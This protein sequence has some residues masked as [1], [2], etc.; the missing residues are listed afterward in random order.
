MKKFLV[1]S[2]SFKGTLSSRAIGSIAKETI[3]AHFPDSEVKA[4]PIADG[5]EG[6]VDTFLEVLGGEAITRQVTGP[7]YRPVDATYALF[8]ETA[9]IEMAA[10]AG[11]PLVV[12]GRPDITTTFGVGQLILDAIDRGAKKIVLGLGGSATNDGGCGCVCALGAKF[13]DEKDEEFIPSGASLHKIERFDLSKIDLKGVEL[14]VMCDIDN[15][16]YGPQ[17]A[18]YIFAPQKGADPELVEELDH[19]LRSLAGL[20]KRDLAIDVS[21]L[22]GAGAAGG[23]GAGMVA[24]LGGSL[25]PGIDLI[26]DLI[27]FDELIKDVDLILTGE[28]KLDEQSVRGKVV[29]GVARRAKKA[30]VPVIALVGQVGDDIEAIYQLGV[31]AVFVTNRYGLSFEDI[32]RRNVAQDYRRALDDSTLR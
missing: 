22:P 14:S 19:G 32:K 23:M 17:G 20:I 5:G 3:L 21:D 11:L 29:A 25:K 10:A 18:A 16:L 27:D 12:E 8:G 31:E 9:V 6:T 7:D 1:L 4:I 26:L 28:G 24:F 30:A 15:P 13:F 2:D